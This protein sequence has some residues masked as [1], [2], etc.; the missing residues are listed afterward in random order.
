VL[1]NDEPEDWPSLNDSYTPQRG[2][3]ALEETGLLADDGVAPT[4]TWIAP[5]STATGME[6]TL[7]QTARRLLGLDPAPP[8]EHRNR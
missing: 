6:D 2:L 5:T 7:I 4:W 3:M 1:G 8:V